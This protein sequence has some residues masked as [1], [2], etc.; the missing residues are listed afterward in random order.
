MSINEFYLIT[1]SLSLNR[2][3]ILT[4]VNLNLKYILNDI[5]KDEK[6]IKKK[7]KN[8]AFILKDEQL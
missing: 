4:Q 6:S 2:F 3:D 1:S 8:A 5:L 7:L